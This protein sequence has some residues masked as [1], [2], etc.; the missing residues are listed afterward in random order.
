MTL[1]KEPT[2]DLDQRGAL[3]DAFAAA[4]GAGD[5]DGLMAMMAS[6]CWFRSS[7]GDEPGTS[8]LGPDQVRT[9]FERFIG[10]PSSPAAPSA[11][12]R[13][14]VS[15]DFAV[16]LWDVPDDDGSIAVRACDIFEFSG[17]QILSKDT[18]RKARP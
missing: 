18:Y 14:M 4:W 5:I 12:T 6:G 7:I 2:Y 13:R 11:V 9:G 10:A 16:V 15:S 8:Y 3:L 17:D 1:S